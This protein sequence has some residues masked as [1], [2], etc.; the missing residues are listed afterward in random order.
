ML[1][2]LLLVRIG[3]HHRFWLPLPVL[4]LWPIWL[5]GWAVWM[6]LWAL[7]I[8]WER[9]VRTILVL[10]ANL[11][12]LRIDVDSANGQHIHVRMI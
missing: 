1:P 3:G 11:S 9:S 8:P 10:G 5:L 2:A 4:L 6:V 12:G 7:R